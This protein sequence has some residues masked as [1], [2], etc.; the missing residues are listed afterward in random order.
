MTGSV[1]AHGPRWTVSPVTRELIFNIITFVT[2]VA[3]CGAYLAVFVYRWNPFEKTSTVTMNVRDTNLILDKT[4]VFVSGVRIGAV[5][6]VD[7]TPE[8]A[9]VKLTYPTTMK[10]PVNTPLEIG[11]Q[12]ALG[13]PYINFMP[14]GATGGPYLR[15]GDVVAARNVGEPES[16]P[17]TFEQMQ[18]MMSV[19][20]VDPLAAVL[21]ESWQAL[22]DTDEATGRISDGSRLLAGIFAS[23][24]PKIRAMFAATQRYNEN[25][26]W[27]VGA[28]PKLVDSLAVVLSEYAGTLNAVGV[29]VNKGGMYENLSGTIGPNLEKATDYLVKILPPTMDALGP[30]MP[31][32]SALNQTIPQINLSE[33]L[34]DALQLFGS[35]NGMRVVVTPVK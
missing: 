30:I 27:T 17:A 11:M 4:G 14:A 31:I 26:L 23:R 12:S 1:R 10:I 7:L 18:T 35:G 20:A 34:S 3:L 28:V 5:S 24:V 32:V 6:A 16:I 29:L 15:D 21:R 33:F 25:L 22:N 2:V 9:S 19:V 13:E 8:G